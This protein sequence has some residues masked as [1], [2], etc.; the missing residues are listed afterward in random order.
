M[1]DPNVIGSLTALALLIAI[2]II[3]GFGAT[4]LAG[5]WR[6]TIA[7]DRLIAE[8]DGKA[9]LSRFQLLVFTMVVATIYLAYAI[10]ALA[11]GTGTLPDIPD[12][13]LGLIGISGGSYVVSKGIQSVGT[14][15]P[16]DEIPV[17]ERRNLG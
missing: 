10:A 2:V 3:G 13:L 5:M 9:S 15:K 12:G 4:L 17:A 6:G 8:E 16:P 14:P 11:K 1:A 7:L